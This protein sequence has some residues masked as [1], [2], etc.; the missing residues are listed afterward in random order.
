MASAYLKWKY[1]DVKP[2]EKAA[3]LTARER[4]ANWWYYHKWY[5]LAG[6]ALALLLGDILWHVLGIGVAEPDYQFAYVGR[7]P[8]PADAAAALQDALAQLGQDCNGDGRTVVQLNQYATGGEGSADY[9]YASY[10][11]LMVDLEQCNSYFFLLDD[12]ASFQRDYQILRRLD[13]T[14]PEDGGTDGGAVAVPWSGCPALTSLALGAYARG[15]TAGDCQELLR[16]LYLARRGFWTERTVAH[17]A[18]CD[19]LW[20][21]L[22]Q[23]SA[24]GQAS[25]S[26]SPDPARG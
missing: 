26:P 2:S 15:E 23:G 22:T 10:T 20:A 6:L 18:E 17:P 12:P 13:G 3:P 16:G 8:L 5:V 1:R 19:S 9:A 4:R 24:A 7:D 21:L 14:L 25:G 11:R